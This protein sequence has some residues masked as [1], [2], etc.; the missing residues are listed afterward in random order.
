M[1]EAV[2]YN[3]FLVGLITE[4]AKSKSQKI[5]DFGAGS[6]TYADMLREAGYGVDC[7]EPD[8]T[9]Q[10]V[11]K[12]KGYK[13]ANSVGPKDKGKYD[14]VYSLNVLEHIDN[15][16]AAFDDLVASLKPGG[17]LVVY[18]PA[19]QV[20]F[21]TMDKRVEHFRRYRKDRLLDF[22]SKNNLEVDRLQYCDPIGF[23]A[24]LLFK[25]IGSKDGV[26]S[27]SSVK[28]YDRFAFPVSRVS[29]PLTKHIFGK[30]VVIV[31][32]KPSSH[33]KK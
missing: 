14:I 10:G 1:A 9:L 30:N 17:K 28:F 7:V 33:A 16:G 18:L 23:F 20:L 29:E 19:F 31:A 3:R 32:T 5:L 8:K 24:A 25:Y 2:N 12:K 26:I 13:V 11:L 22:A 27:P 21:S 6:G 15:D 4:Q